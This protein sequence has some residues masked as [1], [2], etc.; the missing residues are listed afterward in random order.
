MT[1][2]AASPRPSAPAVPAERI[3]A[4]HIRRLLGEG[5]MGAV[6]EAEQLEPVRRRV[7]LK[8]IKLGMDTREI[9]ARFEAERQA[10]ALMDH[11]GIARIY[12]AGATED[13]RPYFAM[14]LV[15][16]VHITTYCDQHRLSTRERLQLFVQVCAAVQH[17]HQKGIIHRDLKPSNILVTTRDDAPGPKIID[18]GIAKAVGGTLTDITLITHHGM[19]MGTPA[20]M[21]PEQAEGGLDV[22]TRTDVYALGVLL[23]EML[24]GVLP[25]EAHKMRG[26]AALV[27]ILEA[28]P[29][30][31]STRFSTL[32]AARDAIAERRRTDAESLRKRLR[33]DLDWIV[34]R[35][36]AKERARRYETANALGEDIERHLA[37][38]P[39]HARP[40]SRGYR[41]GKFVRR[42]R[43]VVIAA[44]TGAI[45]LA[46][47][48]VVA[49]VGMVR[50]TRAEQLARNEAA[51]AREVSNFLVGLF[52]L[53]DPGE[54]AG[55][56]VT[57][58]ELLDRGA[59][60]I[61][62][63]IQGQPATRARLMHA[64][65]EVYYSLGIYDRSLSLASSAL[66][67][68]RA[69][70]PVEGA[71][72]A[73]SDLAA[74]TITLGK[75][76]WRRGEYAPAESLLKRAVG[77]REGAADADDARLAEALYMLG[78]L[79]DTRGEYEDAERYFKRALEMRERV[80]GPD[81]RA[82]A[83][84]HNGL[85]VLY[86]GL[87]RYDEG[88]RHFERSLDI[89]RRVYGPDH[90]SVVTT[91]MNLATLEHSTKN[92]ERA[93]AL[94]RASLRMTE[95][96]QGPDHVD[97]ADGL[98]NLGSMLEERGRRDEVEGMYRRAIAIWEKRLGPD[99]PDIGY[100]LTNLG[101]LYRNTG[102]HAEAEAH[103][104]RADRVWGKAYGADHQLVA[105]NLAG[106]ARLD[107]LRGR[108]QAAAEK[109]AR[110]VAVLEKSM[111]PGT[112]QLAEAVRDYAA[113]LEKLGR[114]EEGERL[115]ARLAAGK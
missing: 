56:A 51:A 17:A 108:D 61:E 77:M 99:S 90:P 81:H 9:V 49:T 87:G 58:R 41:L 38:E 25:F 100:G 43:G 91:M 52:E 55:N 106:W 13:G 82:V 23:Y 76:H 34:M 7:A 1:D 95:Q 18:F 11:P 30:T 27:N 5:G 10:L 107:A 66:E 114:R 98:L 15:D 32:G 14:E 85:G 12:D 59:E 105:M 60:R 103:Y 53:S 42:H 110:A 102:R 19:V 74:M 45:A 47:G 83:A 79:A 73:E 80:L 101:N 97:L 26:P 109:F 24:A 28:E 20:Y 93:E 112:P 72:A 35:A 104:A 111:E 88:R 63:E 54:T 29:P 67:A 46:A 92:Y 113:V 31:P 64:M 71:D 3:D 8:V 75:T 39:V 36:I 21:S 84:T 62:R 50:A 6:Y 16:G 4:Y 33:G 2:S 68:R 69:V 78:V 115:K 86:N 96:V 57:A 89:K 37:N 40:P 70:P 44:G 22:D 48:A 94:M 65:A